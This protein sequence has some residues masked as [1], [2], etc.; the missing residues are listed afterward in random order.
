VRAGAERVL[1]LTRQAASAMWNSLAKT[2]QEQAASVQAH[3]ANVVRET[4]LDNTLVSGTAH[5]HATQYFCAG[6][7][8]RRIPRAH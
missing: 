8:G 6:P 4:G 7:A 1:Y 3:A 2:L 5:A